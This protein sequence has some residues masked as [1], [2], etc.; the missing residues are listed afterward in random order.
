MEVVSVFAQQSLFVEPLLVFRGEESVVSQ[1]V[2]RS[3]DQDLGA[4]RTEYQHK[5]RKNVKRALLIEEHFSIDGALIEAWASQKS[6]RK[7]DE[8]SD[9]PG[10]PKNFHGENRTNQTHQS[11]TDSDARL[12][13]KGPG[14][15][16][17]LSFMGHGW[18]ISTG[19]RWQR[20]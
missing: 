13:R 8:P 2:V 16:A 9:P 20:N 12:F 3:F 15:V 5:V 6:L 18:T 11:T 10:G 17:K 4:I 14:K 1:N 19:W 7:E